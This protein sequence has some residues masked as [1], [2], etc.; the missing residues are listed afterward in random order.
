M[1]ITSIQNPKIKYAIRLR[2]KSFRTRNSQ[3]LIE[4]FEEVSS[5]FKNGIKIETI[6]Y[7]SSFFEEDLH[8]DFLEE[9]QKSSPYLLLECTEDVFKKMAYRENPDGW[10]AVADKIESKLIDIKFRDVPFVVV[11]ESIEKPGNLGTI[12]R[13]SDASGADA[14]IVTDP[15]IDLN[16]PNVIRASVGT[17]FTIKAVESSNEETLKWLKE[18]NFQIYSAIPDAKAEY[19]N[20]DM[21]KPTAIVVGTEKTG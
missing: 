15:T 20:V 17:A 4:G 13:S 3:I 18:N 8:H 10:I 12:L 14:V 19:T 11:A 1:L 5:A 6:F 21:T 2:N 7:C 16:S 9:I